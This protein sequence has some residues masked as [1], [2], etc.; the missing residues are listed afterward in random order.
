MA[1]QG[2]VRSIDLLDGDW[3]A[4][5]QHADWAWMREH[6]PVFHD[7]ANDV[8][9]LTRYAEVME[10]SRD[11]AR[12]S[13][14]QAPRPHGTPM[15]M[16]ISMDDP[17]HARRRKLVSGGFTPRRVRDH[18]ATIE[19]I[20]AGIVDRVCERGECDFVAD[21]AAP[22][23]LLLIADLLGFPPE[24]YDQLLRWSDDLLQATVGKP[25][26][27]E[28]AL[29][30]A[31]EFRE[32]Q[33]EVIADRRARP[34]ADDLV[35][36]LCH[37]EID[38]ERLDDE[39]IVMESMLILIG[40][41]ETSRHVVAD[42]MLALLDH[43]DQTAWLRAD[44]DP[45][46]KRMELAVEEL[47]RWV[48]PIK[49]MART[50]TAPT[51]LAGVPLPV[52]A[53]LMLMYPSANRDPAVFDDAD[54]LVLSRDPNPHVAFGFGPHFCMGASLARLELRVMFAE[55]LRRLPDLRVAGPVTRRA[56][57]FISGPESM[58]VAFTPTARS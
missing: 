41:D 48:S 20:C 31:V 16:M 4:T 3:Y 17:L 37:A 11:P 42:G 51:E 25:E 19:A 46:G 49:N 10:V 15:A 30:A 54:R 39:A 14:A 29:V 7:E 34:P 40:G 24:S 27:M 18:T 56:S 44:P 1:Q 43:P 23:P 9:A 52:G 22:L 2:D 5:E 47:L 58:P 6:A 26:A 8:W 35:S 45:G 12:F 57:N 38:G 50:V 13:S 21:V 55:V 33:L 32:F 53:Q 28:A 36:V